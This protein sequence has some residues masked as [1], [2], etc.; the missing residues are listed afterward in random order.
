[1]AKK[2]KD[3][4]N[5]SALRQAVSTF[6]K[7]SDRGTAL[8]AAAWVDD[9]LSECLR[10]SFRQ[11]KETADKLLEPDRPLGTFSSR[12]KLAYLLGIIISSLRSD[13]DLIKSI[14]NDFAH[15]RQSMR[16]SVQSITDRC[17]ALLGAKAFQAGTGETIRS[18]REKYLISVFFATECLMA[19]AE[20]AKPP[21]TPELN[22]YGTI[23][24]RMAKEMTLQ[25]MVE[26][27]E[28]YRNTGAA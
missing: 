5:Y 17:N 6:T 20:K 15:L 1:M 12:I 22:L 14:R 10:A 11:E 16:F 4:V 3:P 27:L 19:Y 7:Q 26:A 21:D 28:K 23:V 25:H 18:S 13:L 9:A 8:I 24:H 2:Q